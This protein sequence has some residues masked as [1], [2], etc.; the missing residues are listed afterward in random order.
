[1]PLT[2]ETY[3]VVRNANGDLWAEATTSVMIDGRL[4]PGTP[5][6]AFVT[7]A[8]E[9]NNRYASRADAEAVAAQHGGTVQRVTVTTE[10]VGPLRWEERPCPTGT[11]GHWALY[12]GRDFEMTV[13]SDGDRRKWYCHGWDGEQFAGPFDGLEEAKAAV[14]EAVK[15]TWA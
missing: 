10:D 8:A 4:A 11:C 3:Y 6:A 12:D 5:F 14:V 2:A 13:N 1:M 15:A 7:P 9:F